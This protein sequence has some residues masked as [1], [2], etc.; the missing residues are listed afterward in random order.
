VGDNL[1][2]IGPMT[3][4]RKMFQLV[5]ARS[6]MAIATLALSLI[7]TS[8]E[9]LAQCPDEHKASDDQKL[10][11]LNKEFSRN[12]RDSVDCAIALMEQLSQRSEKRVIP[13]LIRNLD[14]EQTYDKPMFRLVPFGEYPAIG[15]ITLFD[16]MAVPALLDVIAQNA[17]GSVLNQNATT[18]FMGI[19]RGD[20]P[21]GIRMLVDRASKEQGGNSDNVLEAAKYAVSFCRNKTYE[22]Q[23]ALNTKQ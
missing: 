4:H 17:P 10:E 1:P 16:E 8:A 11:Y 15:D 3:S 23:K 18:A 19:E 2:E 9:V 21:A 7:A 6:L 5:M 22:C 13:V 12:N 14:L 20:P